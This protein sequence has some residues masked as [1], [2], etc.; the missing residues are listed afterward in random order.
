MFYLM[1]SCSLE[2][3][4]TKQQG[5][6]V[7]KATSLVFSGSIASNKKL[8]GAKRFGCTPQDREIHLNKHG[9]NFK[10]NGPKCMKSST[11]W[12]RPLAGREWPLMP[13]RMR[14]TFSAVR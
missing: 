14:H 6:T 1:F 4:L 11:S 13:Q 8:K 2:C 10:V 12:G 9:Q 5:K 3:V 7:A